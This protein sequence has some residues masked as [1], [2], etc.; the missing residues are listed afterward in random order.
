MH[1]D[2][3]KFWFSELK[4]SQ[5][6]QKD[7]AFDA[8]IKT[9]FGQLHEQAKSGELF[10]WRDTAKAALPTLYYSINL[11]KICIETSQNL[12]SATLSR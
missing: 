4:P 7:V 10:H 12:F 11:P 5:W 2:L 8:M 6:W 9:R 1:N 3:I